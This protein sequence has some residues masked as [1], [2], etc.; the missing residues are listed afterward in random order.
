MLLHPLLLPSKASDLE[1]HSTQQQLLLKL[2]LKVQLDQNHGDIEQLESGLMDH[3]SQ[4]IQTKEL[5][6]QAK[7]NKNKTEP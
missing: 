4:M 5:L 7:R 1:I 6:K 3:I 2:L